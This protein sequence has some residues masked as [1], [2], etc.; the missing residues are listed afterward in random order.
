MAWIRWRGTSAH[1]MA[2][3]WVAGKNRQRYLVNLGG[4]YSVSSSMRRAI[5]DRY[6]DLP[7][8]W[9]A[10]D[11]TL[12]QGPPGTPPLAPDAEDWAAVEHHLRDWALRDDRPVH[13]RRLLE[14]TA[15]VLQDWR[16]QREHEALR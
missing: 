4:V 15:D 2:T 7:I 14:D 12:A 6:P 1:L 5:T 16:I 10:I 13:D 3:V 11:R 8:D 9:A